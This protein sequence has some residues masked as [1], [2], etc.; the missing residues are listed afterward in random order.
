[1]SRVVERFIKYVK[2]D[3]KADEESNTV[4]TTEGQLVFAKELGK[5]LEE[6]G[7]KDVSVDE[8]GYV[9]AT[10][11]AN[12][13]KKVPVVGFIAH[14]DT[15]PDMSATNV[16]PKFVEN[17]D[18]GD[19]KLNEEVILSPKD[20]PELKNYI[21]DTLITTDGTT[22]LG[23]DDKAGIAE[24]ITAVE[25]LVQHPEIPHG[26]IKIG[27]TPDEEVGRGADY[28]DTYKFG[29]DLAYTI[30]GGAIG[31]LEYE[32]FNAAGAKVT[33]QGRNV[34]PGYAKDKMINSML[35][36]NEFISALPESETPQATEGYEGFYHLNSI[37]GDVEKT[38]LNYIIRDFDKDSFEKRKQ[39]IKEISENLNK[40]YPGRVSIEIKDQYR[41]MREKIESVMYV[42]DNA[43]KAMELA[44]VKPIVKPIRGGT[45]GARLSFM[46]L[47]TPNIFTGGLNFHGKYEYVPVCSMEKAVEVILKL[48][49][50]YV[51]M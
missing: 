40:K 45:D 39:T 23:A 14:M 35:I 18:G 15:S 31:E 38:V 42:V 16:K 10:L 1:M 5:E 33:F 12:V 49:D 24:I 3:T 46:G 4:P 21:G 25:Y 51:N 26:T 36:A 34:H 11:P 29:A 13:D 43:K 8:N 41:N 28:F 9:M 27:F 20:F 7:L 6:L 48:V 37:N 19:I 22:L 44:G 47:P 2:F 32:N 30:D 17:Y 50:L